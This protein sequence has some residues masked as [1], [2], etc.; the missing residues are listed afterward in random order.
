MKIQQLGELANLVSSVTNYS[1]KTEKN[2]A[3]IFKILLDL[4]Q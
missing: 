4:I 3:A 2:G 1:V